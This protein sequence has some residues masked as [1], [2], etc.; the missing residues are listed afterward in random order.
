MFDINNSNSNSNSDDSIINLILILKKK[1][2]LYYFSILLCGLIIDL[3]IADF[4]KKKQYTSGPKES[5]KYIF[6]FNTELF[7]LFAILFLI[8]LSIV[9]SVMYAKQS[10]N[11]IQEF[12][13]IYNFKKEKFYS[14]SF[15]FRPNEH[16]DINWDKKNH[17][18]LTHRQKFLCRA[19]SS[20]LYWS[21]VFYS[22]ILSKSNT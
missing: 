4:F 6:I 12:Y 22:H 2:V 11:V 5:N 13:N 10:S 8:F 15:E 1:F 7:G 16:I 21:I 14:A 20:E 9:I 17:F 3:L 18:I 19:M